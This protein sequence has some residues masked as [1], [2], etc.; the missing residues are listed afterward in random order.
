[1][2]RIVSPSIDDMYL[3]LEYDEYEQNKKVDLL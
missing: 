1:M 3:F 2:I